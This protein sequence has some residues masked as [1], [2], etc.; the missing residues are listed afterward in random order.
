MRSSSPRSRV[1]CAAAMP[2]LPAIAESYP[3]FEV[4]T[5]FA[6]LAPAG[7]PADVVTKL[8][9]E[10]TAAMRHPGV[11][12]KLHAIGAELNPGTPQDLQRFLEADIE[13][14]AKVIKQAGIKID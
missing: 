11:E 4:S 5:W 7:A 14:W 8:N 1:D 6:Y 3:G 10:I 9:S 2:Q 13:R 12:K